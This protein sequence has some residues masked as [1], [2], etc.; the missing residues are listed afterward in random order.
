MHPDSTSAQPGPEGNGD[1]VAQARRLAW[2]GRHEAA[3]SLCEESLSAGTLPPPTRIALLERCAESRLALGQ[4]DRATVAAAAMRDLADAQRADA[5]RVLARCC[6]AL[7]M[8]RSTR[9]GNMLQVAES[10]LELAEKTRDPGLIGRSHLALGEARLRLSHTDAALN[11]GRQAV[12]MFGRASDA[13]NLGRAHWLVAFAHSRR[14]EDALSRRAAERAVDLARQSGDLQGLGHALNVLTFTCDDI[15]ERIGLLQQ[16]AAA[17][18]GCGDLRG[19]LI[20]T[21]NL[22]TNFAEMGLYRHARRLAETSVD[23]MNRV[24]AILGT[25]LQTG[26]MITWMIAMGDLAAARARWPGYETLVAQH[27]DPIIRR[28]RDLCA[29][30][31]ALAEGRGADA[32]RMARDALGRPGTREPSEERNLNVALAQAL[33]AQG[34]VPAALGAA[35]R[36]AD[37]HRTQDYARTNFGHGQDVWWWLSRALAADGRG[38]E[39][40][41]PLRHAHALMLDGVRNVHDDGLRRSYLGKVESNRDIVR[42]WL[43]ESRSAA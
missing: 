35:R 17:Y 15:A 7:V 41:K 23:V 22:A 13:M 34:Q 38:N 3:L 9:Y 27:D 24:G 30:G 6:Q 28:E 29:I 33:L 31:L 19:R 12:A 21:F 43:R 18:E 20:V 8:I 36:A 42:A 2:S 4:F 11:H 40:W 39:A 25:T 10:A 1:A 37:I 16:A 26:T 5:P 32:E 14:A